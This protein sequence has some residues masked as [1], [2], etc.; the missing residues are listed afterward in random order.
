MAL[1]SGFILVRRASANTAEQVQRVGALSG[2]LFLVYRL[3]GQDE[4]KTFRGYCSPPPVTVH[5]TL[6]TSHVCVCAG[7]GGQAVFMAAEQP[8]LFQ[9]LLVGRLKVD[10]GASCLFDLHFIPDS[11]WSG[12]G[13]L[14]GCGRGGSQAGLN[15]KA[16]FSTAA[17]V[18]IGLSQ[19]IAGVTG[20]LR[21]G[22]R[23]LMSQAQARRGRPAPDASALPASLLSSQLEH[24]L[25]RKPT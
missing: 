22:M 17:L 3:R 4:T 1:I 2:Y 12:G 21:P 5:L 8:A 11:R 20:P 23:G 16:L 25:I 24:R 13:A 15:D 14:R 18:R 7:A 10:E 19:T 9:R 6:H